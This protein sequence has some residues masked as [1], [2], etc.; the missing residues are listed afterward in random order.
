MCG[1]IHRSYRL[2]AWTIVTMAEI[3]YAAS[4][5]AA[6][7]TSA[8]QPTG[9]AETTAERTFSTLRRTLKYLCVHAVRLLWTFKVNLERVP[10]VQR[11]R[12][13]EH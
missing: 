4:A 12:N 11:I 10:G 13:E 5:R 8:I 7:A 3:A 1:G 2:T 9:P 6:Q